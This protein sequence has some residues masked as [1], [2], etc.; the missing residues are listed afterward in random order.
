MPAGL[1]G[2]ALRE[3]VKQAPGLAVLGFVVWMFLGHI[4]K[5]DERIVVL[6]ASI[7]ALESVLQSNVA[8]L[9]TLNDREQRREDRALAK[10][11]RDEAQ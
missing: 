10:A 8:V 6:A 11:R 2:S 1:N 3:A 7:H 5:S 4:T 9:T